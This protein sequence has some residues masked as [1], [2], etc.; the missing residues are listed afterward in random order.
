MSAPRVFAAAFLLVTTVVHPALLPASDQDGGNDCQNTPTD[1]GDAPEGIQAYSGV[2]AAFP[3]CVAPGPIGTQ[4]GPC[5]PLSTPPAAAGFVRHHHVAGAYPYWLGCFAG[6]F[7]IDTEVDGKVNDNGAPTAACQPGLAVDC[8]EPA[9]GLSFGQDECYGGNDAALAS[10]PSFTACAST[11]LSFPVYDCG[12][13]DRDVFV[14]VLVDWNRDGD[15][16]DSFDCAGVCGYEWAVKNHVVTLSGGC[17]TVTLPAFTA[18]P[19]AGDAW[20]RITI[21]DNAVNDDFPWA[22]S[23]TMAGE[24]RNGETEDYPV[25]I[26][27]GGGGPICP[28]YEDWA[29]APEEAQAYPGVT[30]RFPTCAAA[31]LSGTQT[32]AFPPISTAPGAT[33]YVRHI[34]NAHTPKFYLGC[35]NAAIGTS[36]VDSES[37]GKMND[38][39]APPSSCNPNLLVDCTEA[40]FTL[41]FGQDE[42]TADPDADASVTQPVAFTTCQPAR[43]NFLFY[44][45]DVVELPQFYLN[46]LVDMNQDGDWNDNFDCGGLPA[47]EWAVKNAPFS[48]P[49]GCVAVTSPSFLVGPNPGPSWMRI[50]VTLGPVGD[51]FPWNGSAGP[52]GQDAYESGETEDYPVT[53]AGPD[54]C[55]FG[56]DDF[57]DA[58]EDLP[59]YSSGANG[60]FPTCLAPGAI[61]T[62]EVQCGTLRSTP[63]GATGYVQHRTLASDANHFWLGCNNTGGSPLAAVDA[64]ID[65]RMNVGALFGGPSACNPAQPTDCIDGFTG[66][67]INQDE[68]YGDADAGIGAPHFFMACTLG[69]VTFDAYNCRSTP[70][71]ATL[72][73]L[74]DWNHDG[75]WNDHLSVI[76]SPQI[77][78][79]EWAVKNVAVTLQPGCNTIT[80]QPFATGAT[81]DRAWMRLTLSTGAVGDDFPWAGSAGV[82]GGFLAGGE[83]EDY[84]AN[85]VP[86][87]TAVGDREPVSDLWLGAPRP[88]P[89]TR[90]ISLDYALPRAAEV[91]LAVFDL[92]GRRVIDLVRGWQPAGVHHARW[93]FRDASGRTAPAGQYLVK[94][95]VADRV[96]TRRAI[97]L[98]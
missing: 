11:T 13:N 34:A 23:T 78:A 35:G 75:D 10:A 71:N 92:A 36:G 70:V 60:T 94:L 58:P 1:F 2:L 43:V 84:V 32:S 26:V 27:G 9:F 65:G 85:V 47:F 72:N 29:D 49:L 7:G 21:S 87:S 74:V 25:T 73:V 56:Y 86:R 28:D 31:T 67:F 96:V 45:C 69:T 44:N 6:Q 63:P 33:G 12:T 16:N 79:Y 88:N 66:L 55:A 53:I 39:G 64:E 90:D 40:A 22:G 83:T 38:T 81:A 46:I 48:S 8:L 52:I 89:A 3:T 30:G 50:T 59:A 17:V 98:E 14:N 42:C 97:R 4:T 80:T 20:M 24:L 91:S 77:C 95:R 68:C 62:Q 76:C 5:P 57:G 37:D 82:P 54:T 41:T 18:G 93:D 61:G 15:W 19:S 51:D